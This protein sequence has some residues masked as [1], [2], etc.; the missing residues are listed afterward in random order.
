MAVKAFHLE[1]F[2]KRA[3]ISALLIFIEVVNPVITSIEYFSA[4][5][6]TSNP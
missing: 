1:R 5:S 2:K 3:D 4:L 6:R